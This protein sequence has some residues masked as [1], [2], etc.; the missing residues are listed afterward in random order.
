MADF[1][2]QFTGGET[3]VSNDGAFASA[4]WTAFGYDS[5]DAA[6]NSPDCPIRINDPWP[7][8]LSSSL[9]CD[10]IRVST[11]KPGAYRLTASFSIP[12]DGNEHS[13]AGAVD[14]NPLSAP[15][16]FRWN[17]V[18]MSLPVERDADGNAI[19]VSS[20]RGVDP[21]TYKDFNAKELSVIRNEASF[22]IATALT[23][24]NTVNSGAWGGAKTGEVRCTEVVPINQYTANASY[25]RIA[26]RF[27]FLSEDIFGSEPHQLRLLDQDTM[28]YGLIST[29]GS[30][31]SSKR[32]LV[33][34]VNTNGE[35]VDYPVLL[36]GYGKPL[37]ENITYYVGNSVTDSPIFNRIK[38]TGAIVDQNGTEGVFLR[39]KTYPYRNFM[40]LGL[41][42]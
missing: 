24:E 14:G 25:V 41:P 4:V 26:Y 38:P 8:D 40:S 36:D 3:G 12:D 22:S 19:V 18:K 37:D 20:G 16:E 30:S 11:I 10:R 23:Y 34:L 29:G 15:V 35:A 39:Y 21:P 31:G 2:R 33:P 28:A 9:R 1:K 7:D 6:K 17:T 13:G 42:V 27:L 32:E 5:G